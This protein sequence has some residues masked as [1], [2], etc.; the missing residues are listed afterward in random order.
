VVRL[1]IRPLSP[2]QTIE[3]RS[4]TVSTNCCELRNYIWFRRSVLRNLPLHLI[5]LLSLVR[6]AAGQ[7]PT[8]ADAV[9]HLPRVAHR[10][11]V[12]PNI[13]AADSVGPAF[14]L[15]VI[16]STPGAFGTFFRS[17]AVISNFRNAAQRIAIS[18]LKQ[19]VSS[20]SDP[21]I[22]REL[23]SYEDG[24]DLGL[25]EQDF[26]QSLGKSGLAAVFVQ[27]VDSDGKADPNGLI[28]GFTRVWTNQPPA[29][30]CPNPQGTVSQSLFAV[31][32]DSLS[33]SQF[34][35]FAIG[36]R[37]DEN[38]R[39]NAGIVNFSSATQAWTVSVFGTRG[40]TSFRISVP[41]FSMQQT[42]LPPGIYG[43]LELTFTADPSSVADFRWAAYGSSVDNRSA[44]GWVRQAS[45]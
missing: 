24:G 25:V 33:G 37:Q 35:G 3:T 27:A 16:G 39:T 19:G 2:S 5:L 15:P 42:S 38:F 29:E 45:Y 22:I 8:V 30:G 20:G 21:V 40:S 43:N 9:A 18:V 31:P 13:V 44:D 34:S 12:R 23:K 6:P 11:G 4:D 7:S 36:L 10:V 26:L 41:A 1:G 17:E 14:L 28:D 32:P